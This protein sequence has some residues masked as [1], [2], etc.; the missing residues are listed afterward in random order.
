[1]RPGVDGIEKKV[2]SVMLYLFFE[3]LLKI[4]FQVIED[5]SDV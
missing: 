1:M 2:I 4:D 3:T 5:I